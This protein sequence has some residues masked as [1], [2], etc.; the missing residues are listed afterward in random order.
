MRFFAGLIISFLFSLFSW[1]A[2]AQQSS[3]SCELTTVTKWLEEGLDQEKKVRLWKSAVAGGCNDV[4]IMLSYSIK[5]SAELDEQRNTPLHYL[6]KYMNRDM[7]YH[8]I[9]E[10]LCRDSSVSVRVNQMGQSPLHTLFQEKLKPTTTVAYKDLFVHF[11]AMEAEVNAQDQYGKIPFDY[12]VV[13]NAKS[14]EE[15]IKGMTLEMMRRGLD[16]AAV[17]YKNMPL[18]TYFAQCKEKL[19]PGEQAIWD[20]WQLWQTNSRQ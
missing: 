10:V 11:M 7:D 20:A 2:F 15:G 12:F 1:S 9:A 5:G 13:S 8:K 14:K 18:L 19:K 6:T 3:E 4:A 17:N 16:L